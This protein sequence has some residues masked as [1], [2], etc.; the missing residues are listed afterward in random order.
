MKIL[1]LPTEILIQI[2]EHLNWTDHFTL[3][4]V[5]PVF[6]SVLQ[7]APFRRKRYCEEIWDDDQK[8]DVLDTSFRRFDPDEVRY[9][10]DGPGWRSELGLHGLL[11]AGRFLLKLERGGKRS[12][13]L[14]TRNRYLGR[15]LKS[16]GFDKLDPMM[17]ALEMQWAGTS[18]MDISMDLLAEDRQ[19]LK[20]EE[21]DSEASFER[22]CRKGGEGGEGGEGGIDSSPREGYSHV[23]TLD[24]VRDSDINQGDAVEQALRTGKTSVYDIVG[25]YPQIIR[26]KHPVYFTDGG[27]KTCYF[28]RGFDRYWTI[29]LPWDGP[30][31]SVKDVID[32]IAKGFTREI[33]DRNDEL[34]GCW[35]KFCQYSFFPRPDNLD[36]V[37]P[38]WKIFL[39]V[40]VVR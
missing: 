2:I 27:A 7:H 11:T 15:E 35:I 31:S 18:T 40:L 13:L 21:L 8:I 22:N 24:F 10:P 20:S 30:G 28:D 38:R 16:E 34:L 1:S 23:G 19:Y 33:L 3:S 4:T 26:V 5:S 14:S 37:H 25:K 36:R 6:T 32:A 9:W 29:H 39:D 17:K 12:N